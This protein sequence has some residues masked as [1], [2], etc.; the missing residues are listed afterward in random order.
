M[1]QPPSLDYDALLRVGYEEY[2]RFVN[3]IIAERARLAGEPLRV[4]RVADGSPILSDG[5]RIEDMH[6]IQAFGQRNPEV[7]EA[8]LEYL[9][10]DRPSWFPSRV[11]P[12]AGRLA[13][14]L[15]ARTG[16]DN[17]F[18]PCTGTGAVEAA[19]KLSRALTRR[20]RIL[21]IQGAYHG[22]TFGSCAL[23]SPGIFRDAFGPHLPGVSALPFDD[24]AALE[25]ALASGDVAALVLEP[26][27]GEG[28][29]RPLSEAFIEAACTLSE[30]HGTLLIA[31]EIQTG[32]G[33]TG[34]GLLHSASWSR[35]PDIVLL[36]KALGGGLV[37]ISAMLTRAALFERAYGRDFA[38][39]ESHNTSFAGNALGCIAALRTLELV[40]EDLLAGNRR[41]GEQLRRAL[42]AR[43]STNPLFDHVRGEGM[44]LGLVLEP[45]DH[46]WLSFEHFGYPSLEGRSLV[47][48]LLCRRLYARGFFTF[49]CG[50]DWGVVR[51]QPRYGIEEEALERFVDAC[52][53]ELEQLAE[54]TR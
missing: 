30:A 47:A 52:A 44:M 31:D 29:V 50:H 12:Y 41:K 38:V 49:P 43:L 14:I 25:E 45:I 36:G 32:L 39:A 6:G 2:R 35:R 16:Y 54:D 20:P 1:K 9:H 42:E 26:I 17:A 27:Q 22:C 18:F 10:S 4:E 51:I 46:P 34:R 24:P 23:M 33:R 11:N 48:P 53:E 7:N 15:A 3:P 37:P 28:G 13:A 19:L 21:S 40:D 5:R 8:L